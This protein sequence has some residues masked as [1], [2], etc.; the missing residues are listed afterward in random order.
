M[1]GASSAPAPEG[2][3]DAP[4]SE[5]ASTSAPAPDPPPPTPSSAGA[6]WGWGE[7]FGALVEQEVITV[8][9]VDSMQAMWQRA[10]AAKT[11]ALERLQDEIADRD[12][13]I[14]ALELERAV[15]AEAQA[16]ARGEA[17]AAEASDADVSGRRGGP[18]TTRSTVGGDEASPEGSDDERD[19]AA[20]PPLGALTAAE[21][22]GA[23]AA[24]STEAVL[25]DMR[26]ETEER[27]TRLVALTA[28]LQRSSARSSE[29]ER[30]VA[31]AQEELATR[32]AYFEAAEAFLR[33]KLERS[34][35]ET[36][37]LR[38]ELGA[39]E[40]AMRSLQTQFTLALATMRESQARLAAE[41]EAYRAR[42]RAALDDQRGTTEE[43]E[44]ELRDVTDQSAA[45]ETLRKIA[46]GLDAETEAARKPKTDDPE[47]DG[48]VIAD[49][50][51][52]ADEKAR[53]KPR[54]L[55]EAVTAALAAAAAERAALASE[56]ET[57][58][59]RVEEMNMNARSRS[60]PGARGED[61]E[62]E[63]E[64]EDVTSAEAPPRAV[65]FS[66][67]GHL[68]PVSVGGGVD[69]TSA[70]EGA[71]EESF[72][73]LP[74]RVDSHGGSPSTTPAAADSEGARG[75]AADR[76]DRGDDASPSSVLSEAAAA[77]GGRGAE[78]AAATRGGGGDA[79]A[80]EA[81][82][83]GA[84]SEAPPR[85]PES[86]EMVEMRRQLEGLRAAF[87]REA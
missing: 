44:R 62:E 57:L 36:L 86:P 38:E 73:S 21:R 28:A 27:E 64:E 78:A 6:R 15:F 53:A 29:H 67:P 45:L 7:V 40:R 12:R 63:E 61:G 24:R 79:K 69:T 75:A 74:R 41:A 26:R 50:A 3:S 47:G 14:H 20:P 56:N 77:A 42:L 80:R 51:D 32:A 4:P 22:A 34:C 2:A 1:G 83:R 33:A 59:E 81:K 66:P 43:T 46:D 82:A 54:G 58:R 70:S 55:V 13:R 76:D 8:S 60:A 23:A 10:L 48:D 84:V 35:E 16:F 30:A 31:S 39:G 17:D 87:E 11:R 19:L 72:V 37:V 68:R 65:V 25:R 52:A 5:V 49:A 9:K 85:S 18:S 71:A